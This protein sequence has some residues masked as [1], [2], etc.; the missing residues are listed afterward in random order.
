MLRQQ[1]SSDSTHSAGEATMSS[2]AASTP[3][4]VVWD[5]ET[6]PHSPDIVSFERTVHGILETAQALG[7]TP[8]AFA[9]SPVAFTKAS[10]AA[11]HKRKVNAEVVDP[12]VRSL[13]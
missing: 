10:E 6:C 7:G 8:I 5:M 9:Y 1:L 11:L 13:M 12:E 2:A 3:I 4:L